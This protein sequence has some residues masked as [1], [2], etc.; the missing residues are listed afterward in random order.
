MARKITCLAVVILCICFSFAW[1]AYRGE[2]ESAETKTG[3]LSFLSIDTWTFYGEAGDRVIIT[4]AEISGGIEPEIYLYPPDGGECEASS[5][6]PGDHRLDHQLQQTGLYYIIVSDW[7]LDGEGEYGIALVKIPGAASSEID[8]D[9]GAIASGET[10][11]GTLTLQ[12]DTDIYQFYGEAG[13]RVIITTAEISGGIEPE[14]YLYP[15]D[16]GECEASSTG[17]FLSHRLDH[18]LQQTG[19]YYI[20]ISDWMLDGEGEYGICFNKI[21]PTLSPGIYNPFPPNGATIT[22]LND[23][24]SWDP[25]EGATGYD[26]YFG[27]DIIKPLEKIGENLSSPSMPFPDDM[28]PNKIYYWHVVA[29]TSNGDIEGPYWWFKVSVLCKGDFDQD[30]DVDGLDLAIFAEDF[31]RTDCDTGPICKGNFDGDVDVDDSDL[32]VFA[33]DFGRTDCPVY[34]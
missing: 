23:S 21:P 12:A 34:E 13:D 14:I 29:H 18:Q 22:D 24:F 11:T 9:G 10:K 16:G 28:Q 33:A 25:V 20:I 27:E 32:A 6:G 7:K 3:F 30:G 26:L 17:P 5:T 31:G 4:T 1:G 2:I 15:P 19:L 8:P